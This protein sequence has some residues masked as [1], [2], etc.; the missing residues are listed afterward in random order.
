MSV[1]FEQKFFES[2]DEEIVIY[3]VAVA[4][5]KVSIQLDRDLLFAIILEQ[6][7]AQGP[8]YVRKQEGE[9]GELHYLFASES[10]PFT[11]SCV[12]FRPTGNPG[13]IGK[14]DFSETPGAT[15]GAD[16]KVVDLSEG[17]DW[18]IVKYILI[19]LGCLGL[20]VIVVFVFMR[21][22]S[23]YKKKEEMHTKKETKE[24][25]VETEEMKT[26][27]IGNKNKIMEAIYLR[28]TEL[29]TANTNNLGASEE[30]KE[31]TEK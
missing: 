7:P 23:K 31:N 3:Q 17:V 24:K 25:T 21:F 30:E 13:V 11:I 4:R 14:I 16:V 10:K 9:P 18:N 26:T 8:Q 12:L 6:G 1:A 20:I 19:V 29:E 22:Y 15:N 28:K 27:Q 2:A 5:G